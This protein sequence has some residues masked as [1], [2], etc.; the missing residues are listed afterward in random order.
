MQRFLT[1][2]IFAG[3]C[4]GLHGTA[5]LPPGTAFD[6]SITSPREYFGFSPGERHLLHHQLVGYMQLLA[7]QSERMEWVEYGETHG[8]RP[9]G[10][11]II[12]SPENM[13]QLENIRAEHLKLA[14]PALSH[15]LDID[16]MPVIVNL[17]Y[18]IHGNE[19][20][21]ANAAPVVAYYLAAAT[22]AEID[23]LL[24]KMVILLDPVLNPDGLDRFA[25]WTNNNVG[26]NPNPDPD[27]REHVEPW[28]SGR[29]NYYWFD[30]NRDWMLLTQQESRGRLAQYHSWLPNF[31]LDFHEMGTDSTYFFQPGVPE[32]THP[33]IPDSVFTMTKKVSQYFAQAL[34]SKNAPYFTEER[35]D[36]F[37]TGKGSTISDLKGAI[38]ILFEQASARGIVQDGANG[39]VS[40][41][42]AISNQVAVSLSVLEGSL[43][44]RKEF[45]QHTRQFYRESVELAKNRDFAGYRFASRD[46]PE[47]ARQFADI[48][49]RHS[50]EVY[51][52]ED[53]TAWFTPLQQPQYRYLEALVEQRSAFEESIFYDITAWTLPLAYN[54]EVTPIRKIPSAVD[55]PVEESALEKSDLGYVFP[56]SPLMAPRLLLDLLEADVD[57]KV[58]KEP[59]EMDGKAFGYG[60]LFIP[61]RNQRDKAEA[62]HGILARGMSG[63]LAPVT[64]VSSFRTD[65]GI[66]LGSNSLVNIRKPGILLVA[67]RGIDTYAAGSIWHLL[68]VYHDYPVTLVEPYQ[69]QGLDLSLYTALVLPGGS[70]TVY[71]DEIVEKINAWVRQGGSLVCLASAG[72]WAIESNLVSLKLKVPEKPEN[73]QRQPYA[74]A[75]DNRALQDIKGAIFQTEIDVTHPVGYGYSKS[76]LPVF[77]Q[78]TEFLQPS[79]NAYQSPLVLTENPLLAG[80]ASE[81]NLEL[82]KGSAAVAVEVRGKGSVTLF[83]IDPTFRAYWRGTEKLLLNAILFGGHMSP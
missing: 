15:K 81:E 36:D 62:I 9:L 46:D 50:I 65:K 64:P 17:N 72:K 16:S 73:I 83:A 41:D 23:K 58:A 34:D 3:F 13:K 32:R 76:S 27:T 77:I 2:I 57:V 19:P 5:F 45:L 71:P 8:F 40:F 69:L 28:P 38:G 44:M 10:Q 49:K 43:Q 33:L 70:K 24:D 37:Y 25:N 63:G 59:F 53:G 75:S 55:I 6:D 74:T 80:Y 4:T 7:G 35:F 21:G 39:Q 78:R 11:L 67:G 52:I 47:R 14:D 20:S 79:G 56:W 18:S 82:M 31:V 22:G 26:R 48:L 66:D 61:L 12:S 60:S 51:P 54:L 30:L 68:D 29:S 1:I 42:F